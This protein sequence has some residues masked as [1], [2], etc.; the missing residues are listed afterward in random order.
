MPRIHRFG[1][2]VPQIGAEVWIHETAVIIGQVAIGDRASIWPQVVIRGDIHRIQIGRETNI[3]DGAVLHVSHDS[4][5]LPGGAPLRIG[6]RVT[7][8]HQAVLH[9]CEIGEGCLIGIGARVLDRARIEP[10]TLLGAGS[11]VPPGQVL[12]GGYLWHGAPARRI[13]PLRAQE[14]EQLAYSATHYVQLAAAYRQAGL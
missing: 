1:D 14:R 12:E 13:R 3:Q 8:G 9:G 10:H 11:L 4:P 5:F 6:D 2:Q 7:V